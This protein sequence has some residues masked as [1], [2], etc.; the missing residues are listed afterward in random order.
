MSSFLACKRGAA[1]AARGRFDDSAHNL[2][3]ATRYVFRSPSVAQRDDG[4][5]PEIRP[6]RPKHLKTQGAMT[7]LSSGKYADYCDFGRA[8]E[9]RRSAGAGHD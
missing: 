4:A 2:R 1:A 5:L 3:I 6:V 7:S 9:K 8:A